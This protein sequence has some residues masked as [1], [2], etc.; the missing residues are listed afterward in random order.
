MDRPPL[1]SQSAQP[2]NLHGTEGILAGTR[3][4][5]LDGDLPVEYLE[6]GDRIICR[7]GA[8]RVVSI[9]TSLRRFAPVVR[10]PA[11]TIGHH[12]PEVDLL[13]SPGQRVM[14]R[15]WRAASLYG[16]AVAAVPAARL[17]DGAQVRHEITDLARVFTLHFA[18]EEVIFAEGLEIACSS[19]AVTSAPA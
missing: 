1:L 13:L 7:S 17:A 14:I 4:R 19:V 12:R 18:A 9:T 16:S 11:S 2:E 15:D 8:V 6:P 10:L 5:T 3:V